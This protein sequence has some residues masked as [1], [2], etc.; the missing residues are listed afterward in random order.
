[1][2]TA[3]N[4]VVLQRGAGAEVLFSITDDERGDTSVVTTI[5]L[6]NASGPGGGTFPGSSPTDGVYEYENIKL[7][8]VL[9]MGTDE[10]EAALEQENLVNLVHLHE[11]AI[12]HVITQ[13]CASDCIYTYTGRILVAL[14]PFK[15]LPIYS[16]VV[17][18]MY[19][20]VC[21]YK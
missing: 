7:A 13:R 1:M 8:N 2:C 3:C 5:P 18:D 6:R 11:P 14:N 9:P 21:A 12:L 15:Q 16:D 17:L 10:A 4:G 19:V 20:I